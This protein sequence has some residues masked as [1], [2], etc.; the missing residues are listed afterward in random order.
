MLRTIAFL[1]LFTG[2]L[3]AGWN[4]Y[5]FSIGYFTAP[6]LNI[7][8]IQ[9]EG[10]ELRK[11]PVQ[12]VT[13]YQDIPEKGENFGQ[14]TIPRIKKTFPIYQGTDEE[15]LRKGVGHF[16]KSA[17]P[18]EKNNVIL[19]GH[20]DTVFRG[21]KDLVEKDQLL[22]TTEAGEFLYKIRKI[23]IVDA[24]DQ[25]VIKPKPK[26]TLTL[27]TCYPFYFI[28]DAPQRYII[29]AEMISSTENDNNIGVL[30]KRSAEH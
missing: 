1:F 8:R 10:Q 19:S 17:L 27:T 20:R 18:G 22:V 12:N 7:N 30:D 21:L 2:L 25:T 14:L 9:A 26:G 15:T 11:E 16:P 13:L 23:R 4:L 28:G 5:P 6:D 3:F 29:V 24:D